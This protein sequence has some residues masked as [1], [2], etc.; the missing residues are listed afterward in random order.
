MK[1]CD[2]F[3]IIYNKFNDKSCFLADL[4]DSITALDDLIYENFIKLA[5]DDLQK[6]AEY[7]TKKEF[8]SL[9]KELEKHFN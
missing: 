2:M 3:F 8:E 4:V 7:C 5:S 1:T 9:N 6:L